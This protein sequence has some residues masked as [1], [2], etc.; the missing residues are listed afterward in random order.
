MPNFLQTGLFKCMLSVIIE[1]VCRRVISQV[2]RFLKLFGSFREFPSQVIASRE[3]D[4]RAQFLGV[5]SV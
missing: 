3:F 5:A 2:W 4:T 1:Y